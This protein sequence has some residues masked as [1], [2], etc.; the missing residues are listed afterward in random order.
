MR[1]VIL[2]GLS[3]QSRFPDLE[4]PREP[5]DPT[6]DIQFPSGYSLLGC[7]VGVMLATTAGEGRHLVLFVSL[8]AAAPPQFTVLLFAWYLWHLSVGYSYFLFP[9]L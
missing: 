2:L 7:N 1:R 9:V 4:D 5:E 6:T 8:A 3:Q